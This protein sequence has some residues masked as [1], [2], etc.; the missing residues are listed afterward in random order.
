MTDDRDEEQWIADEVSAGLTRAL[1]G[2]DRAALGDRPEPRFRAAR[3][4]KPRRP[5]QTDL[6]GQ[7]RLPFAGEGVE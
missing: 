3:P 4:R 2:I 5:A 6:P 7:L 1:A